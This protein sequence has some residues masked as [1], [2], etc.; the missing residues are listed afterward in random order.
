MFPGVA[1]AFP[2]SVDPPQ[3][4]RT[5]AETGLPVSVLE[6]LLLKTLYVQGGADTARLSE[7]VRLPSELLA[8]IA[9]SLAGAGAVAKGLTGQWLLTDLGREQAR[10]SLAESRYLG[11]A[12][13]S[14]EEY[15][16]QCRRQ[17]ITQTDIT[18]RVVREAFSDLLCDADL[19]ESSAAAI[20]LGHSLLLHGPAGNGKTE[21]ARRIASVVHEQGGVVFQP[22]SLLIGRQIWGVFDPRL[23]LAA[24]FDRACDPRWIAVRRPVVA[25]P[26]PLMTRDWWTPAASGAVAFV[27]PHVKAQG[28][29]LLLDS[30]S[31][32]AAKT[33]S[34]RWLPILESGCDIV[35]LS[36]GEH[37]SIPVDPLVLFV[38]RPDAADALQ[39]LPIRSRIEMGPPSQETLRAVFLR[40]CERQNLP[41]REQLFDYMWHGLSNPQSPRSCGDPRDLLIAARQISR[42][43]EEEECFLTPDLL[44]CAARQLG[45]KIVGSSTG[46]R[47]DRKSA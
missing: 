9:S 39:R 1:G 44:R 15:S 19:I 6:N 13:V 28:G 38:A 22:Q 23:H 43:R 42:S 7:I 24:P 5:L 45:W 35:P 18:Q 10:E 41:Y 17:S 20:L 14:I 37:A 26:A 3:P 33:I 46:E 4:P 32:E 8:E 47:S 25:W 36:D 12:P 11:P 29:A 2:G 34:H 31:I 16:R 30:L 40:E 27:P 21:V